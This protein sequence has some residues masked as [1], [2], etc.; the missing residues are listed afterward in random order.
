MPLTRIPIVWLSLLIFLP[1]IF[2]MFVRTFKRRSLGLVL[3]CMV[4]DVGLWVFYYIV[5]IHNN[6]FYVYIDTFGEVEQQVTTTHVYVTLLT[7]LFFYC[8]FFTSGILPRSQWHTFHRMLGTSTLVLFVVYSIVSILTLYTPMPHW[9][10]SLSPQLARVVALTSV[11]NSSVFIYNGYRSVGTSY[12]EF[13]MAL[14]FF[15]MHS[16]HIQRIIV[17]CVTLL[18]SY[19]RDLH[20]SL[21]FM[22]GFI[23]T[24][25]VLS[26][27]KYTSVLYLFRNLLIAIGSLFVCSLLDSI[28]VWVL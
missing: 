5:R 13:Q 24:T 14:V 3:L 16:T 15:I 23:V 27:L 19:E 28:F 26:S 22:V 10:G 2:N 25:S 6:T 21:S 20:H 18:G 7:L 8:T 9:G 17:Y 4:L 1:I 12:H 11:L